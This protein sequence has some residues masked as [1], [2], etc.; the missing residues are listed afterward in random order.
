MY[1]AS[2]FIFVGLIFEVC[3]VLIHVDG[4]IFS[5]IEKLEQLFRSE[6]V[7]IRELEKFAKNVDDDYLH[8]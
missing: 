7:F 6:R 4:E 1:K 8:R 5:A 2:V 3:F